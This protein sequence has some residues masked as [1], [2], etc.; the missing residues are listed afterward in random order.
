[1]IPNLEGIVEH[2][3]GSLA[4]I[5]KIPD[6]YTEHGETFPF[7]SHEAWMNYFRDSTIPI[8]IRFS[9]VT[10]I[11]Q[12][13]KSL[14][15][16]GYI[17]GQDRAEHGFTRAEAAFAPQ[18]HT[19]EL[20]LA[21]ATQA[22]CQGLR[23]AERDFNITLIPIIT[24]GREIDPVDGEAIADVAL[25]QVNFGPVILGL[26][27]DEASHP[28]EKH[29]PAFKKIWGTPVKSHIHAAE[30]VDPEPRATYIQ[31]LDWNA[32]TAIRVLKADSL[33]HMIGLGRNY[34]LMNLVR[35]RN[36]RIVGCPLSE[37]TLRNIPDLRVLNILKII[38]D[39]LWYTISPD[40]SGFLPDLGETLKAC[41]D[42]YQFT[43]EQC[44][45]LARNALRPL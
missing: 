4:V 33:E 3:D 35:E 36:I 10:G 7:R 9:I 16:M 27:C 40:D 29:L 38:D 37:L 22:V 32:E 34:Y 20:S 31:R 18:Y 30:Q 13:E 45:K 17:Y 43:P 1:M 25:S 5:S 42:V 24:I 23:D 21:Q 6:I 41:D 14:R 11:L 44:L 8:P 28:P 39:D 12:D 2:M 26:G 15:S 19:R